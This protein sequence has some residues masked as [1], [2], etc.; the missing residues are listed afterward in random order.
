M[1]HLKS[2]L[3]ENNIMMPDQKLA[4]NKML[5]ENV[6]VEVIEGKGMPQIWPL[7]SVMSEAKSALTRI[8]AIIQHTINTNKH[9]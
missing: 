2:S 8:G 6:K 9:L 7:L 4:V 5:E 3:W 1:F